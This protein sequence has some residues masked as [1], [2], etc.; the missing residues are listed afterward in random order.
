VTI[1]ESDCTDQLAEDKILRMRLDHPSIGAAP[2]KPRTSQLIEEHLLAHGHVIQH[3]I[4]ELVRQI[5]LTADI[6]SDTLSSG[7]NAVFF[8]NGGSAACAQYW[9]SMLSGCFNGN[10][11]G[12]AGIALTADS[13]VLTQI[14][15]E[16]G[17]HR[18]FARQVEAL[19]KPG[20]IVVGVC[21]NG[22]ATN[23]LDGVRAAK[24]KG[25]RT[26]ALTGG[27]GGQLA[28]MVDEAIV[29]PSTDIARVREAHIIIAHI[30]CQLLQHQLCY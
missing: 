3:V 26:V 28:A 16:Y 25:A 13:V 30:V 10:R 14:A 7:G 12:L 11:P 19:V 4:K 17:Y 1:V 21:T 22:L 2:D 15:H 29:I 9:A 23:V 20:D 5:A 27:D 6:M 8:G 18:I 24:T